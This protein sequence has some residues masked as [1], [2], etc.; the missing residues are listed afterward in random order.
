MALIPPIHDGGCTGFFSG[1]FGRNWSS[2]CSEHDEAFWIGRTA[3]EFIKANLDQYWCV[4]VIDPLAA[5]IMAAVVMG[6]IGA[7]FFFFGAKKP[8]EPQP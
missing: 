2:C 1:W 8:Q 4:V 7:A 3:W 5:S 6:P